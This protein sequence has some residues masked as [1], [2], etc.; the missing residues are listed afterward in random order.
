MKRVIQIGLAA[1]V[2]F[3]ASAASAELYDDGQT[4]LRR[5]DS[6]GTGRV[7]ATGYVAGMYDA[8]SGILVR[9]PDSRESYRTL[10]SA[11]ADYLR[12]NPDRGVG[13]A[14]GATLTQRGCTL[15]EQTRETKDRF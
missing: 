13:Y 12:A 6:E 11:V 15:I 1:A 14:L 10:A 9:C 8:I 3:A 2:L 5:Y 4:W 7:A